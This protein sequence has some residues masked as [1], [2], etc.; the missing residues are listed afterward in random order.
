MQIWFASLDYSN[1][2][3]LVYCQL[4][5][6]LS[7][8]LKGFG[9][10][11]PLRATSTCE[12]VTLQELNIVHLKH[13]YSS[14]VIKT[15][16]LD[17]PSNYCVNLQPLWIEGF[18]EKGQEIESILSH[19]WMAE[20]VREWEL[21]RVH[22]PLKEPFLFLNTFGEI[23][24]GE[25]RKFLIFHFAYPNEMVRKHNPFFSFLTSH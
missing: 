5:Q 11:K 25:R 6:V 3:T 22:N 20:V 24:L 12:R 16:I 14:Y 4:L 2:G 8:A 17:G 7:I 9:K 15:W 1:R 13:F 18:Q 21:V 10:N 23:W 19:F